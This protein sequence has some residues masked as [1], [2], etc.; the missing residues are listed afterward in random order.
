MRKSIHTAEYRALCHELKAAR[1]QAGLSQRD[2]AAILKVPHSWVAKVESAER[3]I[4]LLE[5]ALFLTSCGT[6]PVA[7]FTRL[8]PAKQVGRRTSNGGRA[9]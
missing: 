9:R 3:R 4:D 2:L 6:D 7:A 1:G 8:I 5:F